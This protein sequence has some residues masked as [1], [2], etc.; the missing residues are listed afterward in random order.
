M[1]M[2]CA[3]DRSARQFHANWYTKSKI[4]STSNIEA[5]GIVTLTWATE[6]RGGGGQAPPASPPHFSR[7]VHMPQSLV[8]LLPLAA[9]FVTQKN[10]NTAH[11]G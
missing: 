10:D 7:T 4:L 5:Y 1:Y 6:V 2:L 8:M 3:I 9:M 11:Q